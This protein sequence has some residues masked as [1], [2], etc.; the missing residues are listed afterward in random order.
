VQIPEWV[1]QR[2]AGLP[3]RFTGRIEVNCYE[4]SVRNIT[5]LTSEQ[6]PEGWRQREAA[7]GK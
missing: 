2:I 3:D 1:I 4:G 7:R 5:W 6:P